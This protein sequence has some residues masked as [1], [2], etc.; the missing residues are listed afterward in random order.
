[1]LLKVKTINDHNK[2]IV[3]HVHSL[4]GDA[5]LIMY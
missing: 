1:M 3:V 4:G 5:V 2:S